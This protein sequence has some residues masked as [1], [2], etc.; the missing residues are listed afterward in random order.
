[1]KKSPLLL[2]IS[3]LALAAPCALGVNVLVD[4]GLESGALGG[5]LDRFFR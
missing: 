2:G 5:V 1:M 4:G 3:A